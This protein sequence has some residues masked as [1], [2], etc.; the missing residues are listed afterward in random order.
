MGGHRKIW[1]LLSCKK[2]CLFSSYFPKYSDSGGRWLWE[3]NRSLLP[4]VTTKF[5]FSPRPIFSQQ[6]F[7]FHFSLRAFPTFFHRCISNCHPDIL[8]FPTILFKFSL[9]PLLFL[10]GPVFLFSPSQPQ[11]QL[12]LYFHPRLPFFRFLSVLIA[13]AKTLQECKTALTA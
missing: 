1:I 11:S 9:C 8:F 10:L 13:I 5:L 12:S 2:S 6:F 4:E 3:G 7:F